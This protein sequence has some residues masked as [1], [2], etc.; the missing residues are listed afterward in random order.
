MSIVCTY[1]VLCSTVNLDYYYQVLH[2]ENEVNTGFVFE[3]V[4]KL[5]WVWVW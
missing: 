1:I 5:E 2:S 4:R 3:H